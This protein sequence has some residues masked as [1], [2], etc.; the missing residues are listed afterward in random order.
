MSL[1]L[2]FTGIDSSNEYGLQEILLENDVAQA[3][4]TVY[5]REITKVPIFSLIISFQSTIAYT[6]IMYFH[7][8]MCM[9]PLYVN[10]TKK[11]KYMF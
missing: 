6:S 9:N 5:N 3:T 11:R 10:Y 1:F 8:F 4:M 7:I 2:N